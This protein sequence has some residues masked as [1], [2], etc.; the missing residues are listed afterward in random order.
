MTRSM[1][2]AI[3]ASVGRDAM[4]IECFRGSLRYG[5]DNDYGIDCDD[6]SA[7]GVRDAIV[8]ADRRQSPV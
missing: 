8:A 3:S 6:A 2:K 1:C 4:K 7:A 5:D